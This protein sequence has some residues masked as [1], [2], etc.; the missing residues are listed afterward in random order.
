MF[1][2]GV[3]LSKHPIA[4]FKSITPEAMC[5]DRSV[6]FKVFFQV[7]AHVYAWSTCI[8]LMIAAVLM[9]RV[10]S[11]IINSQQKEWILGR[12]PFK[13]IGENIVLP[14]VCSKTWKSRCN[15][16]WDSAYIMWCYYLLSIA[17]TLLWLKALHLATW[18]KVPIRQRISFL[19]L[20]L[21]IART[22]TLG[23]FHVANLVI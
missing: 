12:S 14:L 2:Y 23:T 22:H 1:V 4:P 8:F 7:Q 6:V 20:W 17:S 13:A 18:T 11:Q 5:M 9:A 3:V 21:S 19:S 15:F 16:Q 10:V